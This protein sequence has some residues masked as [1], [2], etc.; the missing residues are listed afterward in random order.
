MRSARHRS[1]ER[2]SSFPAAPARPVDVTARDTLLHVS[3]TKISLGRQRSCPKSLR[4]AQHGSRLSENRELHK[5]PSGAIRAA[6]AFRTPPDT[7]E[8][9]ARPQ[10]ARTPRSHS[11]TT[12]SGNSR[13]ATS[14]P[15]A[16]A[17]AAPR[18]RST[19]SL[20][21]K[22]QH[23]TTKRRPG[24]LK[25]ESLSLALAHPKNSSSQID[26]CRDGRNRQ[27]AAARAGSR[28]LFKHELP[29]GPHTWASQC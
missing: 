3:R 25:C 12:A 5:S 18:P 11:A 24:A 26:T 19:P 17:A 27:P 14:T 23:S 10:S 28:R 22:A 20:V 7:C 1:H 13:K 15:R 6:P 4:A 9:P 21:A 2:S 29:E 16:N 8:P